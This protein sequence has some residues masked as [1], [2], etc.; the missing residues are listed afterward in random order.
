VTVTDVDI[1]YDAAVVDAELL[2]RP[3][4]VR[5]EGGRAYV[6]GKGGT[7]AVVDTGEMRVLGGLTCF[8]DAQVVCPVAPDCCYV[9]D[10]QGV[11]AVDVA[12]P[13][14]P[15]V[16]ASI[17]RPSL[18]LLNGWDRWG[19][20][21]VGASKRG[22]IGVVDVADPA[23]PTFA[24][25]RDT[26]ATSDVPLSRD[27][28]TDFEERDAAV[29][30][31]PHD[32]RV[33]GHRAVVPDQHPHADRKLGVYELDA[34]DGVVE[35]TPIAFHEDA[36]LRGANRVVVRD[37]VGY[38]AANYADTVGVFADVAGDPTLRAAVATAAPGP[39][40]LALSGDLLFVGAGATVEAYDVSRDRYPELAASITDREHLRT[41]GSAHD[42]DVAGDG[43]FVTAQP[44]DRLVRYEIRRG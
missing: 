29:V 10:A 26:L 7:F 40:G 33:V 20:Y 5:V 16:V 3:H 31:S 25:E 42:M 44:A 22:Y 2:N 39:N 9:G 35:A 17:E 43:L 28:R 34:A 18:G 14:D 12:D 19:P 27:D 4:D 24:G 32:V 23:D 6:A 15:T 21:L 37:G 1:E 38:V 30:R 8:D 41:P 11:F 36:R 13:T